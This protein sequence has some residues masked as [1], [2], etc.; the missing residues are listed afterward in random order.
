MPI[1]TILACATTWE[2]YRYNPA[3]IRVRVVS[4]RFRRV[5]S[6]IAR[7]DMVS[8]ALRA[9]PEGVQA[10]V[11]VAVG[12]TPEEAAEPQDHPWMWAFDE[13]SCP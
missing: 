6:R 7:T 1:M 10:Q 9:L 3:S 13:C 11:V 2:R 8:K 5:K 4:E 12:F